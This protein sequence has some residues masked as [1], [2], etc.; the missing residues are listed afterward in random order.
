M[1]KDELPERVATER[2]PCGLHGCEIEVVPGDIVVLLSEG[3]WAHR[4]H[5][6]AKPKEG[7]R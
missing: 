1:T 2:G 3:N 6:K 7:R 4:S 5:A